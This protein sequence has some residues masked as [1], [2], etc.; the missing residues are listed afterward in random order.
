MNPTLGT[1]NLKNF[2]KL[3]T[4]KVRELY[5]LGDRLLIVATDRISA[6]DVVFDDLI[7]DKGRVL[8]RMTNYWLDE[9]CDGIAHHRIT[10]DLSTVDGLTDQERALV[11][12]EKSVA[13]QHETAQLFRGLI[14]T[15]VESFEKPLD[16]PK[17]NRNPAPP[18]EAEPQAETVDDHSDLDDATKEQLRVLRRM[19]NENKTDEEL[20]A[21][22]RTHKGSGDTAGK[23]GWFSRRK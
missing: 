12:R 4:G 10:C 7:P 8:T 23:K 17:V 19:G 21:Q 22:L 1:T 5:D 18:A 9:I 11:E 16:I 13:S 14:D 6:Y 2:K 3:R 15:A 20:L